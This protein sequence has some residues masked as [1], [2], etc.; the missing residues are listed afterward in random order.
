MEGGSPDDSWAAGMES[1]G[2]GCTWGL[3]FE[4]LLTPWKKDAVRKKTIPHTPH[5]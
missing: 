2:R 3:S 1:R 4:H 5:R